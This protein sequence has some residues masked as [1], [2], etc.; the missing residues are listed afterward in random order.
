MSAQWTLVVDGQPY[1]LAEDAD[2]K[3]LQHDLFEVVTGRK[4]PAWQHIPC[5]GQEV[6]VLVSPSSALALR[7]S[8][9]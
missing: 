7:R 2:L 6:L 3:T 9:P 1:E 4:P 8:R 5:E